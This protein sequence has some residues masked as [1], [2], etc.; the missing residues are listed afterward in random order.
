MKKKNKTYT[1]EFKREAL[2]LATNPDVSVAQ[3]DNPVVVAVPSKKIMT[4][5]LK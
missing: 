1:E 2:K 3:A 4:I 5:S